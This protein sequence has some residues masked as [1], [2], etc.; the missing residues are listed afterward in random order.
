M[1]ALWRVESEASAAHRAQ[2]LAEFCDQFRD[3]AGNPLRGVILAQE[4]RTAEVMAMAQEIHTRG[5]FDLMPLLGD[6]L[7]AAGCQSPALLEHCRGPGP[8]VRGC[9]AISLI[10]GEL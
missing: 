7:E 8:H 4:H 10:C 6:A 1:F 5:L 2:I 9:W 3:V